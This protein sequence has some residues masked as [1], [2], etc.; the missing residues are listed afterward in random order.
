MKTTIKLCGG[1]LE[2]HVVM[3]R[4]DLRQA[5]ATIE[6]DYGTGGGWEPTQYQTADAS[7]NICGLVDISRKL[8]ADA[9]GMTMDEFDCDS[10]RVG[11]VFTFAIMNNGREVENLDAGTYGS[12]ASATDAG[13]DA[14]LDLCPENSP[15][16][17][18]Y[19]VEV[20]A[21]LSSGLVRPA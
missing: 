17:I 5:S 19:R 1:N 4:A 16:R 12:I 8:A 15:M 13:Y 11:D 10:E 6:A 20:R 9:V 18:C 3:V 21:I 14:L 7:H 2:E